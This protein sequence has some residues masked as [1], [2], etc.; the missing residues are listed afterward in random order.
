MCL[1][2]KNLKLKIR[3]LIEVE[4]KWIINEYLKKGIEKVVIKNNNGSY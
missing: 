1:K 3:Y 2:C 4:F